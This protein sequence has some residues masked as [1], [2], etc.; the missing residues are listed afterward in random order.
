[1]SWRVDD[2]D[3]R[4][5][6]GGVEGLAF[7][8]LIFVMGTLVIANAW[9]VIDTK[10]AVSAAA[11]EAARAYVESGSPSGEAS[12]RR[13]AEATMRGHGHRSED[14]VVEITSDGNL[15]AYRRCESAIATVTAAV[16]QVALPLLG[17]HASVTS[18]Q[19]THAEVIDPYRSGL[20]G[21]AACGT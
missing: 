4:G 10:M 8:V 1:M 19:A 11:R 16:P 18:V 15:T 3:E 6:V 17:R 7:G 2:R 20:E 5:A 13:A 12:A 9:S 21:T 14:V